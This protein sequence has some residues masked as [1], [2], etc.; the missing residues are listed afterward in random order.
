MNSLR[1]PAVYAFFL[2]G[3]M[4]LS[5]SEPKA[6]T[7][8]ADD[9]EF[10]IWEPDYS[11]S[12][13]H[14]EGDTAATF[15]TFNAMENP[16]SGTQSVGGLSLGPIFGAPAITDAEVLCRF[17]RRHNKEFPIEVAEA[18]LT[19]GSRY[20]IR[21]DVA[22][23]QAIVETGWF[24]F[25]DGTAVRPDQHNY[26]GLGVTEC[27]KVGNSF[28]TVEQGVTAQMQHL[29]A[30]ACKR[31]LP[32]GEQLIDPRFSLVTRGIAPNWDDLSNRWAMNP[33]YGRQILQLYQQLLESAQ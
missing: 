30:Y 4:V 18:F 2:F 15:N 33:N 7:V 21:G 10:S 20:G 8:A 14:L 1:L 29:Y 25:D 17:V 11:S 3:V 19:V 6:V 32:E 31:L 12:H 27:G 16:V 23:C 22:L 5:A 24:R 26:C 13:G 9:D 28:E